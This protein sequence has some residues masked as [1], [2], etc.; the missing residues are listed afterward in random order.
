MPDSSN[1]VGGVDVSGTA[2]GSPINRGIC[3]CDICIWDCLT[4]SVC[5]ISFLNKERKHFWLFLKSLQCTDSDT[6]STDA[7]P[8]V[9]ENISLPASHWCQEPSLCQW[10]PLHR[11]AW[12][13]FS[14]V[15]NVWGRQAEQCLNHDKSEE[16]HHQK[17]AA[18][19]P[20]TI[21]AAKSDRF[22]L[23]MGRT[24][25]PVCICRC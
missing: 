1:A 22:C 9:T 21:T 6:L 20:S 11:G 10:K 8:A 18:T 19:K 14:F 23:P 7:A 13:L 2:I 5:I 15:W 3:Y 25:W 12:L 17:I 24:Y 4:S 16:D